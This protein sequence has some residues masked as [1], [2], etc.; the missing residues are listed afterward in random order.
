MGPH[1]DDLL[2]VERLRQ[3]TGSDHAISPS[4]RLA[5]P[6]WAGAVIVLVAM[7]AISNQPA[8]RWCAAVA[9]MLVAA[10]AA[11][12]F[13]QRHSKVADSERMFRQLAHGIPAV[14]YA[15]YPD[16]EST[17][18]FVSAQVA[19]LTGHTPTEWLA[20]PEVFR[21][22][23]HP[24]DRALVEAMVHKVNRGE[25]TRGI[26]RLIHKDGS[27][28][29]VDD[30]ALPEMAKDGSVGMIRG[31]LINVT[32]WK[33]AESEVATAEVRFE[34]LVTSLPLVVY[35]DEATPDA[36]NVY[37]S[38]RIE[39]LTGYSPEELAASPDLYPSLVH[40]EDIDHYRKQIMLSNDGE[41]TAAE[42]RI[43]HR[44]GREVWVLDETITRY[45]EETDTSTV[46]GFLI[47]VTEQHRV[48]D[49]LVQASAELQQAQ[50]L[51]AIGRLAGGIAHDFNN[52]LTVIGGNTSYLQ[53]FD[54]LPS[55][56]RDALDDIQGASNTASDL[57]RQ[58]LAYSR[59]NHEVD[60]PAAEIDLADAISRLVPLMSSAAGSA[61]RMSVNL[62]AH[63]VLVK[64]APT[65]V[66][67]VMMNLVVNARDAMDGSGAIEVELRR[68]TTGRPGAETSTVAELIVTDSGTGI[69]D[70]VMERIWEPF[71]TTKE[72]G[73]GSG[74]G[75]ATVHGIVT[76]A[77]GKISVSNA[78][79]GGARF[80]ITL[81]LSE[82]GN[83]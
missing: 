38:P 17:P 81:P 70:D 27:T 48:A 3:A 54:D 13:T 40:P 46:R 43:R 51:E 82:P 15:D 39:R 73:K 52:L 2:A 64:I 45:D 59:R 18:V 71:F 76:E 57:I 12:F 24:D 58:L 1:E 8:V 77:G 74:L 63:P 67:Q 80:S 66:D 47:D 21:A 75:L 61:V 55:D 6:L 9:A 68:K 33:I 78:A 35:E 25:P 23:V 34:Q 22:A 32:D 49:A 65:S 72:I 26:Y 37:V 29:W 36:A 41:P 28:V 7:S 14:L 30:I 53:T 50:K 20:S 69:P 11:A 16:N 10:A 31:C 60:Q 4:I 42:Y 19:D 5:L 79:V 44:D 56:A 62:P 83:F